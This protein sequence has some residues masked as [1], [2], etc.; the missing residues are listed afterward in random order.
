M[1]KYA[2]L[3]YRENFQIP[4]SMR[5]AYEKEAKQ[6][7]KKYTRSLSARLREAIFFLF[8]PGGLIYFL[9]VGSFLALLYLPK[10]STTF[11]RWDDY[12]LYFIIQLILL[13]VGVVL[14]FK[15]FGYIYEV[16]SDCLSDRGRE[17]ETKKSELIAKYNEMGYYPQYKTLRDV[18]ENA[19][20]C[21]Y[22]N[23]YDECFCC[24]IDDSPV[25]TSDIRC[26]SSSFSTCKECEKLKK[27]FRFL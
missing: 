6:V 23:E 26:F 27:E 1:T 11:D 25:R 19:G 10:V 13:I 7:K 24:P 2:L 12:S 16:F 17:Y 15:S 18:F 4:Q 3:K 5:Q 9:V 20:R 22:Y 14:T 21:A 8:F